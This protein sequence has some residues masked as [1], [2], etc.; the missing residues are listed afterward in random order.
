MSFRSLAE[1]AAGSVE[2]ARLTQEQMDILS[3]EYEHWAWF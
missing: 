1:I 2:S 3:L